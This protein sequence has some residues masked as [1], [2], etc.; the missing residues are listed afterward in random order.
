MG[1]YLLFPQQKSEFYLRAGMD[2]SVGDLRKEN[3]V[4]QLLRRM[5]ESTD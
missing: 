4:K 5:G 3:R 1:I 2:R